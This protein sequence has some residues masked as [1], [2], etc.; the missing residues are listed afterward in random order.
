MM[1]ADMAAAMML[2]N[3]SQKPIYEFGTNR[4]KLTMRGTS[5]ATTAIPTLTEGSGC[6]VTQVL[7]VCK[8][9]V[10]ITRGRAFAEFGGSLKIQWHA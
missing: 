2:F 6:Q 3:I 10:M 7:P 9:A 1:R 5:I 8:E 4:I